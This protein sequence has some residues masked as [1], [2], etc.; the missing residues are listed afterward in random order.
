[1]RPRK[2]EAA[3]LQGELDALPGWSLQAGRLHR[4][5]RFQDFV[6]AF[7]FMSSMAL[8]SEALDHHPDWSNVYSRVVID[9]STHDA[10]G[11]TTLDLEWAK[12]ADRLIARA[13]GD[14][15]EGKP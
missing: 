9:L 15:A 10:D 1:M 6:E 14:R 5:L 11:I 13:L 2:L 3:E 7:G 12:R 8:V 4:E